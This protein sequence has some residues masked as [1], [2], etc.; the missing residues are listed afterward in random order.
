MIG[1]ISRGF[2]R[3]LESDDGRLIPAGDPLTD[4]SREYF[5]RVTGWWETR[6][7]EVA[8]TLTLSLHP[9]AS[10]RSVQATQ[11]WIESHPKAP[12]GL[13][14]LMSENLDTSL[15]ALRAQ[16]TDAADHG[17]ESTSGAAA[18][19]ASSQDHGGV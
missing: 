13:A 4:F 18:G 3:G 15:R 1:A 6:T 19:G 11:A 14:R 9:P 16:A 17:S 8:Q 10:E 7:L 5:D 12:K 2:A